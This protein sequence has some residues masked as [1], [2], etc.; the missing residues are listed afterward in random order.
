MSIAVRAYMFLEVF[1]EFGATIGLEEVNVPVKPPRHALGQELIPVLSSEYGSKEHI[2]LSGV[3]INA[4]ERKQTSKVYRIHLDNLS[5]LS[6][7]WNGST[8]LILLPFGSQDIF[9]M[10]NLVDFRGS[11]RDSAFFVEVVRNLFSTTIRFSLPN[12]PY[13]P[14]DQWINLTVNPR[15]LLGPLIPIKEP[16]ESVLFNPLNPKNDRLPVFS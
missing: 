2:N 8:L 11:K 16:Q 9:L 12:G 6:S 3:D 14:L 10:K 7:L 15:D 13:V 5:R 4:G 1:L